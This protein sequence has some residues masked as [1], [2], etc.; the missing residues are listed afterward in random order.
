MLGLPTIESNMIKSDLLFFYFL[1]KCLSVG[2]IL[3]PS[4]NGLTTR[5]LYANINCYIVHQRFK[6]SAVEQ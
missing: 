5:T 3:S 1:G 6:Y 4:I 2:N